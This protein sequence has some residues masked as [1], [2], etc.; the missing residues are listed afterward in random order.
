M[1]VARAHEG[2]TGRGV[3]PGRWAA[4]AAALALALAGCSDADTPDRA[5]TGGASPAAT[6]GAPTPEATPST[7]PAPTAGDG[8][9]DVPEDTTDYSTDA[10][11][12]LQ[13]YEYPDDP[14]PADSVLATLCNLNQEWL[15]GLRAVDDGTPV[16]DDTLRMNLVSLKDQL[17]TW[18]TLRTHAPGTVADIDTAQRIHDAW[19]KALLASD[20]G[21]ASGAAA[22]MAEGEELIA[23][24]P[25]TSPDTC[26]P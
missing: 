17:D 11:Q 1:T 24:L 13:T 10:G 12:N 18:D 6:V 9:E 26:L 21:D 8:V 20:N 4:A 25:R 15:A 23:D 7:P 19:D 5:G 22:S 2:A 3:R 16:V 14:D